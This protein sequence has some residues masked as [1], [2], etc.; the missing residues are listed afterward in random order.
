MAATLFGSPLWTTA[1]GMAIG[2][3]GLLGATLLS[4]TAD[5]FTRFV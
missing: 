1:G 2:T 4:G 3:K 5:I